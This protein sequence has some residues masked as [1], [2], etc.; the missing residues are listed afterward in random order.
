MRIYPL[1]FRPVLSAFLLASIGGLALAGCGEDPVPTTQQDTEADAGVDAGEGADSSAPADTASEPDVQTWDKPTISIIK[2]A[3]GA[4]VSGIIEIEGTAKAAA[5]LTI[6]QVA[7]DLDGKAL[8]QITQAPFVFKVD[9]SVH[10]EGEYIVGLTAIDSKNQDARAEITL[11]IDRSGPQLAFLSPVNNETVNGDTT[12]VSLSLKTGTE[13][14]STVAFSALKGNDVDVIKTVTEAP[15]QAQWD[16]SGKESGTWTIRAIGKD[17]HG[18]AT[19]T[20][21]DVTLNRPPTAKWVTPSAGSKISGNA[22]LTLQCDDDLGLSKALVKTVTAGNNTLDKLLDQ[23]TTLG[24]EKVLAK[25]NVDTTA[26]KAGEI[27]VFGVCVDSYGKESVAVSLK[28]VVDQPA[29]AALTMCSG[30]DLKACGAIPKPPVS[31]DGLRKLV[32]AL[33]DDDSSAKQVVFDLDGATLATV[34][35]APWEWTWDTTKSAEGPAKLTAKL[36]TTKDEV[37]ELSAA[38]T[39]NNCDVD[40][41][42]H[43]AKTAACGGDDCNDTEAAIYVGA[44]DPFG[45]GVDNNCD[46]KDG[47]D[48]DGDGYFDKAS[49]GLDCNDTNKDVH[50]CNDDVAGDGIDANCDGSDDSSCDDC[51]TC[52]VDTL[53]DGKCLHIPFGEGGACEDGNPCSSGDACK[54]GKCLATKTVDCNDGNLCTADACDKDLK[55]VHKPS[56]GACFDG[57]ACTDESCNDGK[58]TVGKQVVCDDG[59]DCTQD[60]CDPKKGCFA[61]T[62]A[63]G[64]PCASG[65]KVGT[66]TSGKCEGKADGIWSKNVVGTGRVVAVVA[67]GNGDFMTVGYGIAGFGITDFVSRVDGS[68]TVKFN[69]DN[70]SQPP[71]FGRIVTDATHDGNDGLVAVGFEPPLVPGAPFAGKLIWYSATGTETKTAAVNNML[72][73]TSV[74][75]HP[76]EGTLFVT[77]AGGSQQPESFVVAAFSSSGTAQ[78]SKT[79]GAVKTGAG[80]WRAQM[81]GAGHIVAAGGIESGGTIVGG[82]VNYDVKGTVVW[83]QALA[84]KTT[85]GGIFVGLTQTDTGWI[86][87]GSANAPTGSIGNGWVV[88]TDTKGNMVWSRE[89]FKTGVFWSAI[90]VDNGAFVNGWTGQQSASTNAVMAQVDAL[91]NTMWESEIDEGSGEFLLGAVKVAGGFVIAGEREAKS[92][93]QGKKWILRVDAFGHTT[94]ATAG[95]CAGLASAGCDDGN[96]CTSDSCDGA[97]GCT[98]AGLKD[99]SACGGGKTC[100]VSVC[101]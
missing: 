55:C 27:E 53:S 73:V 63:D 70:A 4:V 10:A 86:A 12:P 8:T 25:L 82:L 49:G 56:T 17:T 60:L 100:K 72:Q 89:D 29:S 23:T 97:K 74:L 65:C 22:T 94:C 81:N 61:K 43:L 31:I 37:L 24:K 85:N 32:V 57:D 95:Q 33:T 11:T 20:S 69:K 34:D 35:K 92:E 40:K 9:T 45:D 5:G 30:S 14:P 87:A 7:L 6:T 84:A 83:Q 2:P 48:T 15:W 39:I 51:D 93:A 79:V 75:R 16:T 44:V 96:P 78:W 41:D 101:Q 99:G 47:V 91:G 26:L 58:C 46:G 66:C 50:P 88:G 1:G 18:N 68:G 21:V 42:G 3:T 77:G 52:S 98:H 62:S 80:A 38:V 19:T 59:I 76:Q 64:A 28:L 36:T 90:A 71:S 54:D 13:T 67:M